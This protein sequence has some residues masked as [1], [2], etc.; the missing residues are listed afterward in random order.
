MKKFKDFLYD[1][2]DIL[3]AIL[4]L[5]VAALVIFWRMNSIL[6]Y[7]NHIDPTN[8]TTEIEEPVSE[9]TD[10]PVVT[11]EDKPDPT[12]EPTTDSVWE[13]GKLTKNV[14]VTIKGGNA[15]AAVNCLIDAGLF[16]SYSEYESVCKGEGLAP[17]MIAAGTFNFKAGETKKDIVNWV[18]L[19]A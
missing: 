19:E 11:P 10:E 5:I 6:D 13:N 17:E 14:K 9:P 7:P 3:I 1:N 16:D 8:N 15:T 12:P 4:I 18:N 2:N